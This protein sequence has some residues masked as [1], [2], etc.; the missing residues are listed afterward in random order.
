MQNPGKQDVSLD[1][2]YAASRGGWRIEMSCHIRP[3]KMRRDVVC[4]LAEKMMVS[5]RTR[6][7]A[8]SGEGKKAQT[9]EEQLKHDSSVAF[10]K[11]HQHVF[12][13]TSV[14]V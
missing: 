2:V 11:G 1:S 8:E 6:P 9:L 7:P 10:T 12:P 13:L 14:C 4:L 5:F 3:R